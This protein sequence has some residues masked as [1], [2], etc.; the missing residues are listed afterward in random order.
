VAGRDYYQPVHARRLGVQRAVR[1]TP[2]ASLEEIDTEGL[3]FEDGLVTARML[4]ERL[5][6]DR[7]DGIVAVTDDIA[8]GIATG[9]HTAFIAEVPG[10]I[11]IV[12]CEDNRSARSGPV[13]LTAV[14]LRGA[15][16]GEAAAELLLEEMNTP[17]AEHVHRTITIHPGLEVR[18]S[19]AVA[20]TDASLSV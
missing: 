5:A 1:E 11:S 13:A 18:A 17:A 14:Q 12:G 4:G 20:G 3:S 9:L 19:T 10:D 7:P 6:A 8:N 2:E 16:M 15:E